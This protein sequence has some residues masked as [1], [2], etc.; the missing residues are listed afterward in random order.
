MNSWEVDNLITHMG[1]LSLYID[2][3]E[4]D[5]TDLKDDL[6]MDVTKLLP[7]FR[8]LGC[9]VGGMS[10]KDRNS[11][12]I[13]ADKAKPRRM[14]KLLLPLQFPLQGKVKQGRR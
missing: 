2:N 12:N 8:E 6:R 7:Y 1:A 13:S 3:W 10:E 4:T 9:R 11:R 14:A 5:T